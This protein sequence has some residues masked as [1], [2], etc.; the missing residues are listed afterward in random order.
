M[1]GCTSI[2]PSASMHMRV[3]VLSLS[4]CVYLSVTVLTATYII[5]LVP[6][7]VS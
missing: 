3:T 7:E 6:G 2:V 5:F 4:V 1:A